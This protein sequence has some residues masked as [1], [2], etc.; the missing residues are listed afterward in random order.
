[1]SGRAV[2]H[3]SSYMVVPVVP[4]AV[5]VYLGTWW[6]HVCMVHVVY[7]YMDGYEYRGV[8]LVYREA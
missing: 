2:P 3:P 5:V 6:V 1:M 7:G 4:G 8:F